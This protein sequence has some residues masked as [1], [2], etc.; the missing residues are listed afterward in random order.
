MCKLYLI[1]S[2]SM[3]TFAF[4]FGQVSEFAK[5]ID[6][7]YAIKIGRINHWINVKGKDKCKPLFLWLHGGPGGSV[8]NI[9]HKFTK[10]LEDNFVVVQWD[11]RET[12]KTL[13]LNKSPQALT[14]TLF[15]QDTRDLIDSLLLQFHQRKIYLAAHSWGTALGFYI[16]DKYPDLLSVL[17]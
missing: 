11:Q 15:Q 16:A 12:G 5:F 2:F 14:L 3:L 6:T 13:N 17:W 7:S 10:K 8:M 1:V 4:S 9:A